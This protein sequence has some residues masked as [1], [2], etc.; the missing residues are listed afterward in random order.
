MANNF[1]KNYQYIDYVNIKKNKVDNLPNGVTISTMCASAKRDKD[2]GLGGL[3]TDI[4]L[5]NVYK[6]MKLSPDDI[7]EIKKDKENKR[8]IIPEKKKKRR[9]KKKK[10]V[11]KK[12]SYFFH[13][14]T[15]VV[16][17]FEGTEEDEDLNKVKKINFKVFKNGSIQ[18]SGIK[19]VKELNRAINKLI[20][21]L[22]LVKGVL[23]NVEE[24]MELKE[25]SFVDEK[26]KLSLKNFK[27][28]MINSNYMVNMNINRKKLYKLLK[29][30]N[31]NAIYER[32]IRACVIIKYVPKEENLEQKEI[33]IFIFLKGNII[34]TGAKSR[35]HIISSYNFLNNILVQHCDEIEIDDE[36]D[37]KNTILSLY[38]DVIKENSH[39]L[40]EL[41]V[42]SI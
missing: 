11:K 37:V 39:K 12:T 27:L 42:S 25:I 4:L 15:I 10:V 40:E 33:S 16:R 24:K 30:K 23:T 29:K 21:N 28:D 38:D 8:T 2:T 3:G 20:Y 34:I 19:D 26:E 32:C 18:I 41:N 6:Y 14:I 1:W 36:E 5:P 17:I 35:I 9:M 13:Q 22:R 31:V 7:L